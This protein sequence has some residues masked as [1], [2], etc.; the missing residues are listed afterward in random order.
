MDFFKVFRTN[1]QNI[2]NQTAAVGQMRIS[3]VYLVPDSF[4]NLGEGRDVPIFP[5]AAAKELDLFALRL[6]ALIPQRIVIAFIA[7]EF[8]LPD[9]AAV[10]PH[11]DVFGQ[12]GHLIADNAPGFSDGAL[13]GIAGAFRLRRVCQIIHQVGNQPPADGIVLDVVACNAQSPNGN[14]AVVDKFPQQTAS[15]FGGLSERLIDFRA[16]IFVQDKEICDILEG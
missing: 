15:F 1:D 7:P 4:F 3:A 12:I 13:R 10:L 9:T 2:R 16:A 5:D 6:A 11:E 14:H 8:I